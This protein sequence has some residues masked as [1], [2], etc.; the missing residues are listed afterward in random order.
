MHILNKFGGYMPIEF[1]AV[2]EGMVVP[3]S[4]VLVQGVN[5]DD[6]SP[7]LPGYLE[8]CT[9]RGVWY[10]TTVATLSYQTKKSMFERLLRTSDIPEQA[11]QFMLHDFGARGVSSKE[12]AGLGGA[13]HLVNFMGTDTL[14][15]L[16]YIK[17]LYSMANA[18]FS[19]PAAEHST[20]TYQGPRKEFEI[21]DRYLDH[22]LT[23]GSKKVAIV[24][25]SYDIW[26]MVDNYWCDPARVRRI[27]ESGGQAIVRPDSG[28]PW[29]VA[30]EVMRRLANAYGTHTNKK[31]YEVL[32]PSIGEIQGD[33]CNHESIAKVQDAIIELG[34]SA[35]NL[36]FG[37]GGGLLQ[38][39]TRDTLGF[40]EKANANKRNGLWHD[41]YKIA[42][43]KNS[44]RGR[45]A[46][47]KRQG[48]ITTIPAHEAAFGE[49]ILQPVF[50]NGQLLK[51]YN[52]EEIR[53]RA[54]QHFMASF[55]MQE[56]A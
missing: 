3:V 42:P 39:V 24:S 13:G 47:V 18:A 7:W 28:I 5:T 55:E 19:I 41:Q 10:P 52:F 38:G 12:S 9:L 26:N 34:F 14:E 43:G 25:D 33:G 54:H 4:N 31:G 35:E 11:I 49:N 48:V 16:K 37:M 15:A 8:T 56:A 2:P 44:K 22:Y 20:M 53:E 36:A 46:L 6:K 23:T 50:R 32:H 1:E 21:A 40:A 17:R 27:K 30:P 29:E 45:L 51:S